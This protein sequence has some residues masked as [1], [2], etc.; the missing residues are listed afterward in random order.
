MLWLC[1]ALIF[2]PVS[3][4]SSRFGGS[5]SMAWLWFREYLFALIL[6]LFVVDACKVSPQPHAHTPFS[7]LRQL[8]WFWTVFA[9]HRYFS[10]SCGH[11][12]WIPAV[13]MLWILVFLGRLNGLGSICMHW[14]WPPC[15]IELLFDS[16]NTLPITYAQTK[17]TA[18]IMCWTHRNHSHLAMHRSGSSRQYSSFGEYR[19]THWN[20]QLLWQ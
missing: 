8:S 15:F 10:V 9:L 12:S 3:L 7:V 19:N 13:Q 14:Y 6:H 5:A 1:E 11:I 17:L 2:K 4:K 18:G 20:L 16:G